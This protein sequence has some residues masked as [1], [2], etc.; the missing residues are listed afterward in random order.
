MR[1]RRLV[2]G[3]REGVGVIGPVFDVCVA[4]GF[5]VRWHR[6]DR[7]A[8]VSCADVQRIAKQGALETSPTP[9]E[10]PSGDRDVPHDLAQLRRQLTLTA[11]QVEAVLQIS[12]DTRRKW[13]LK[14]KMPKPKDHVEALRWDAVEFFAWLDN[15]PTARPSLPTHTGRTFLKAH[16]RH[17][18]EPIGPRA[19]SDR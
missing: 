6:D 8:S 3:G 2:P 12:N 1:D 7:N 13:T 5:P 18:T 10:Q 9:A 17:G 16:R 4:C 15:R 19:L 11:P 14:G